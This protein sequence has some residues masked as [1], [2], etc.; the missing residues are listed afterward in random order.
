MCLKMFCIK[1]AAKFYLFLF[2]WARCGYQMYLLPLPP[3][4]VTIL[5]SLSPA[6][7][8]P[9]F[10]TPG[11]GGIRRSGT[12][13]YGQTGHELA[14]TSL[15]FSLKS[16]PSFTVSLVVPVECWKFVPSTLVLAAPLHFFPCITQSM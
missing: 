2:M 15:R 9:L 13:V 6:R 10:L 4:S 7:L 14:V 1:C 5:I 3:V 12:H 16:S 8:R 11:P